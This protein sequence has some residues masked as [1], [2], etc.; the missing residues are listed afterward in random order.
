MIE[1]VLILSLDA[2]EEQKYC[3]VIGSV[4]FKPSAFLTKFTVNTCA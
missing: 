3:G 1:C 4:T 2:A